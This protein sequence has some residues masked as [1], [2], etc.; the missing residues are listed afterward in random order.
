MDKE[1]F[2]DRGY[3]LLFSHPKM[4][5]D[6]IR[7]FVK[8]D[9]TDKI[10]YSTLTPVKTSFIS[11]GFR[12]RESDV[13]WKVNISQKPVYIYIFIDFQSTVDKFMSLR[14]MTYIGLFYEHLLKEGR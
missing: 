11:S 13:I 7:T 4:V 8:E 12:S 6:L 5:E 9:F 1:K 3:K 2:S 10:D 14:L